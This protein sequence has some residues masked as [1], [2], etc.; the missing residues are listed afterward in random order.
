MGGNTYIRKNFNE[1]EI[2]NFVEFIIQ[3]PLCSL[4]TGNIFDNEKSWRADVARLLDQES[5]R[6]F[7]FLLETHNK[8][9]FCNH[10]NFQLGLESF[11]YSGSGKGFSKYCQSCTKIGVWRRNLSSEKLKERGK[12]IKEIKLKFYQTYHGK[13]VAKEIGRK[14]SE[15]L[16][17]FFKTPKGID[18]IEKS[19]KY[20]QQIMTEKILSGKFTPNSNNKNTYWNSYYK[21]KKFRSSWEALYQFLYPNDEYE[22]LRITYKFNE[23]TYIYIVDFINYNDKIVTEV[24]PKEMC[25]NQKFISKFNSLQYWCKTNGFTVRIATQEFL[26]SHPFPNNLQNFDSKSI[27]KIQKLYE[28]TKN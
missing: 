11:R 10:C 21:D 5:S 26:V 22:K 15:K 16:K 20:N 18:N 1:I 9:Y 3:N 8:K 27:Q 4:R 14:N 17:S 24:K 13:E 7:Y 6:L 19:R 25:D 12:K 23:K 2:T 28:T